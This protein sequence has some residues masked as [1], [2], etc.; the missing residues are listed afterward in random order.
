MTNSSEPS[1]PPG[2]SSFNNADPILLAPVTLEIVAIMEV[3]FS[4]QH[5]LDAINEHLSTIKRIPD[6]ANEA[7]MLSR[8][9]LR[10]DL[11]DGR[12]ALIGMEEETVPG[13]SICSPLGTKVYVVEV[14]QTTGCNWKWA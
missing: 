2:V 7:V 11:T 6:K 1:L 5:L 13:L 10:L 8:G 14:L 3:Q 12:Q 4:K 9:M